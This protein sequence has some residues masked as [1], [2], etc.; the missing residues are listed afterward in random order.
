MKN[1]H[2]VQ[3]LFYGMNLGL[4]EN[5]AKRHKLKKDTSRD[6]VDGEEKYLTQELI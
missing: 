5:T 6:N 3:F 1:H 4:Y 2:S